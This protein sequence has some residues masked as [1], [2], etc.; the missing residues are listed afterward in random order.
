MIIFG[1]YSRFG[2][3][4][5][6]WVSLVSGMLINMSG[7]VFQRTWATH[8]YP[9]LEANNWVDIVGNFLSTVS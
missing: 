3:S 4:A 1:F 2:T 8:I 9:W 5:G 6:A 7:I